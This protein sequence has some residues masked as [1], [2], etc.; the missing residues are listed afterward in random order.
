MRQ[1]EEKNKTDGKGKWEK[2][3]QKK[4]LLAEF[5]GIFVLVIIRKHKLSCYNS[6]TKV[7]RNGTN[8]FVQGI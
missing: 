4:L 8:N 5:Q 1:K 2:K 3:D 7:K 6:D